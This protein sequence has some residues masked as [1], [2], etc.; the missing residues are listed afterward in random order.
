MFH[1]KIDTNTLSFL[2]LNNPLAKDNH[3]KLCEFQLK[4]FE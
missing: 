4:F 3:Q 2:K 1:R